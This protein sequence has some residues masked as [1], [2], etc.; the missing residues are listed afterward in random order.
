M[1]LLMLTV[2][3]PQPVDDQHIV[4]GQTSVPCTYPVRCHYKCLSC[5]RLSWMLR[6]SVTIGEHLS[7]VGLYELH[8]MTQQRSY[9][10]CG[11]IKSV[12]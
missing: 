2:K 10:V 3:V 9:R 5:R 6:D 4:A 8:V 11:M 1:W 7:S 12:S